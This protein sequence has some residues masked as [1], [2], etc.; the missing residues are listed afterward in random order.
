MKR[1]LIF[2]VAL[3]V[4]AN[5]ASHTTSETSNAG[6]IQDSPSPTQQSAESRSEVSKGSEKKEDVPVAFRNID[7]RNSSYPISWSKRA[8]A[9]KEGKREFFEDAQKAA[10]RVLELLESVL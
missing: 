9:L 3:M 10:N 2:T 8:I 5:C 1:L 4:G 6:V 7:F